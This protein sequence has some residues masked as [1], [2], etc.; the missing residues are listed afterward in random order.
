MRF[1]TLLL[2][3]FP[4]LVL[5]AQ[6]RISGKVFDENGEPLPYATVYVHNSSNGTIS[7]AQGEY[8]LS[9]SPGDHDMVFQYIGYSTE[10]KAFHAGTS[11]LHL[12][13]HLKPSDLELKEVVITSEDPAVRIMREV[14]AKRRYYKN[15]VRDY[16]FDAYIKGFYKLLD[17]PQKLLGQE[18]GNMG[19][20]LDTN[21][22]GVIYL[23]E[24]VSRVYYRSDPARKKEVMIS[25]KVSG[26][27]K[28]FSMN[29]ATFTDFDLYDEKL[30]IEREILSPLADNAFNYYDFKF[31]GDYRDPNGATI[32]KIQ[33]IPKRAAD[34]T[35]SG[36]LY[37]VDSWWNL[38]GADLSLT[39]AAIKQPV[40]DTMRI[41]QQFVM[42]EQPD[43][44]RLLTQVTNFKFAIFGFKV[45]GFFNSIFSHY[46]LKPQYAPGFFDKE[47]F[48]VD[49]S[50][51]ERDTAYWATIRPV[52]L[53]AEEEQD[54]VKKDSL[55]K[56][57]KSKEFLDSLDRKGNRFK[58]S[59]L[60]LGYTW[61]NS[62]R[63]RSVSWPAATKWV[64]FNTVQGWLLDIQPEWQRDADARGTRYWRATGDL[65]YGFAEQ[66]LRG[67]LKV[68]R[69]LESI[70]YAT[71]EISGGTA[72]AQFNE[73]NPITRLVNTGYSLFA[74]R[75]YLKLYDKTYGKI[76][77]S[78]TP[79]AGISYQASAEWARRR[80]LVNH[81]SFSWN[82]SAESRYT[83]NMPV[84]Q[85]DEP[86]AFPATDLF[87]VELNLRFRF[88]QRYSTYPDY[89]FYQYSDKPV[90]DLYYRHAFSGVLGSD[91][92]F[93]Y[94]SVRISQ[95]ALSWGLAGYTEWSAIGG[96]FFRKK[97][98]SFMDMNQTMGNQTIFGK[99][100]SYNRQFLLFPYYAYATD[101][102]F[103]EAHAQ[104]HL[105]GWLLDKIPG[106]RKLNWKE[107]FGA[108][109]LYSGQPSQDPAYSGKLPYWE[110]N[111]G[112]ENIG[113]KAIRP[114]RVDVACGFFGKDYYRTGVVIGFN[115]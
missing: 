8:H 79:V 33:V 39:G 3:I 49:K 66:K 89:R 37:V 68:R 12:D 77:F 47:T 58:A 84:P 21:R 13:A 72:T 5:S 23:S 52:P 85:P 71:L 4:F 112:F 93:N 76:E 109:L 48:K 54:Y 92:D 88:G 57:W 103:F 107:V 22:A 86:A 41:Q 40:L 73:R 111:F 6:T 106:L 64:Q 30:E 70:H 28:G 113:I 110:V 27:D 20:I 35:F 55:Q 69:R 74:A 16:S 42:L 100:N 82:K 75:N 29:R 2:T 44:W 25:S 90:I 91:A 87:A 63:H 105:Q 101:K 38:A 11:P 43:T 32:D 83:P 50:A 17:A 34:P 94:A 15:K 115:L 65:N 18:V 7:N 114:L 51:T 24:S 62:Y 10:V 1:A 81:T 61:N 31:K 56:I 96:V 99:P 59:N 60:L 104:H 80:P 97:S 67:W 26:N 98:M 102:P 36:Y 14:I 78:Q 53:T 95:D 46:D 9:V 108:S 45:S 19:G